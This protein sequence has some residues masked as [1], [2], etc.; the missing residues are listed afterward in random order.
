M[1]WT[2]KSLLHSTV[3]SFTMVEMYWVWPAEWE[4]HTA[5]N[6][7]GYSGRGTLLLMG[8]ATEWEGHTATNGCGYRVGGANCY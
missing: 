7:C 2:P 5:T 1:N 3:L 4:G 8:V 6:G